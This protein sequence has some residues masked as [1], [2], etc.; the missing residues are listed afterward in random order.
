MEASYYVYLKELIIT[1]EV[2]TVEL[3]PDFILQN[4]FIIVEG[5]AYPD[6]HEDFA[7][8][9][10]KHKVETIRAIK[11]I[12]DFKVTYK[13]GSIAI[14]DTKGIETTDF[15]I[16]EKLFRARY[17]QLNLRIIIKH[18][19]EWIKYSLYKKLKA[20]AKKLKK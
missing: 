3:Q 19:G 18:K 4:K 14:I 1:G 20:E 7:K 2:L 11:Y 9:K 8:L 17:P 5:V 16:K 6:T 13:D 10:R 12:S 15:K